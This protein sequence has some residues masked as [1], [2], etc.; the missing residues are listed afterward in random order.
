VSAHV[1]EVAVNIEVVAFGAGDEA[2]HRSGGFTAGLA[3]GEKPILTANGEAAKTSFAGGVVDRQPALIK[4]TLRRIGLIQHR[5]DRLARA[6]LGPH[7]RLLR[8]RPVE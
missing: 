8:F 6:A 5:G 4:V 1:A 2:E 3:A 7:L